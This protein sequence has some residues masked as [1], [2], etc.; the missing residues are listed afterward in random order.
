MEIQLKHPFKKA[1]GTEVS[2]LMMRRGTRGDL[3]AASRHSS[4]DVEQEDFLFARLTGLQ[5]EDIDLIDL[6]DSKTLV[7]TFQG[8]VGKDKPNDGSAAAGN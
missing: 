4:N 1:D 8:M 7:A 2:K 3:K 5:L 6:E